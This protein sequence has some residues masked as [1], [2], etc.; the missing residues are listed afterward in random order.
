MSVVWR[1][2]RWNLALQLVSVSPGR[3]SAVG[4]DSQQRSA[5]PPL[6][7]RAFLQGLRDR[8]LFQG[9]S[10]FSERVFRLGCFYASALT[11][12]DLCSDGLRVVAGPGGRGRAEDSAGWDR[13]GF[14]HR[15]RWERPVV[16]G[17][18]GDTSSPLTHFSFFTDVDFVS[19]LC[20]QVVYEGLVDDIFRIKCGECQ[21]WPIRVLLF[22]TFLLNMI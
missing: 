22:F 11:A 17:Q 16:R 7:L 21:S 3:G 13:K 1:E 20:S 4:E 8:T 12:V 14:P 15:Q 9:C 6:P 19:P 5:P 2:H 18:S 10:N